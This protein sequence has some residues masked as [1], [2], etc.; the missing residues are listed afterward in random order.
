MSS[1]NRH[2]Q[3]QCYVCLKI[4]RSDTL[5]RHVDSKH[6]DMEQPGVKEQ[7]LIDNELHY[8]NVEVGKYVF[9]M[10]R[11][12]DID[13]QSLSKEHAYA[14]HLYNKMRP[15]I[16]VKSAE[17]RLWQEQCLKL[18]DV[19]TERNVIWI[20]GMRGNEGK[21]WLQSY[22]QSMY[23]FARTVRLDFKGKANGIYLALSK[24]PLTTTDIFM[25]NDGRASSEDVNPCYSAL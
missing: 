24:R 14:L 19:P 15:I 6:A 3:V 20:K 10:V 16:D 22:V 12:G 23:G 13:Q 4:M 17:L 2:K 21:S 11:S 25:F 9:D 5:Q 8:K 1:Q 7:L 18:I